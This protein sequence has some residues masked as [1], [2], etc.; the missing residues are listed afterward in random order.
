MARARTA[1]RARQHRWR[2]ATAAASAAATTLAV[3]ATVATGAPLAAAAP[4]P[5]KP[6]FA[7]QVTDALRAPVHLLAAGA[8]GRAM[9]DLVFVDRQRAKTTFRSCVNRR[10]PRL[11]TCFGTTSGKAGVATVTPLR[12]ARGR[13]TVTW[14]VAGAVVARWRF[15]VV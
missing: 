2:E 4:A 9:A 10:A 8:G 14:K 12:F 1:A 3:A 7:G 15:A 11:S 5:A 13:Y 6:R